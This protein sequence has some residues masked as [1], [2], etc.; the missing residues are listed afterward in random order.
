MQFAAHGLDGSAVLSFMVV[1]QASLQV[2]WV[3]ILRTA[4][5]AG[6]PMALSLAEGLLHQL[7]PFLLCLICHSI[8]RES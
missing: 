1:E 7:Q 3:F 6:R 4:K 8:T 2:S 5:Q